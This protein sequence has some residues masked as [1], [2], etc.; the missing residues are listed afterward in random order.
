MNDLVIRAKQFA[1][2][3]HDSIKQRRKYSDLPYWVHTDQVAWIVSFFT[4][5]KEVIAA[6]HLHDVVED[7]DK[8][9]YT[10]VDIA[11]QFGGNVAIMVR[12]LTDVYTSKAFPKI[13][14]AERKG[15]EAIRLGTIS[16]KSKTIKLADLLSNGFSIAANDKGFAKVFLNEKKRDLPYLKGGNPI[17]WYAV[18]VMI[19]FETFWLTIKK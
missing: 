10:I 3:A 17:L 11:L 15:L 5:D 6:S 4:R 19:F 2:D 7:V 8:E 13:N 12:E 18:K 14:R 9:P 1:H 16:N